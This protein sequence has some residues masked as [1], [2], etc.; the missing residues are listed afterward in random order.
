LRRRGPRV[1]SEMSDGVRPPDRPKH[2]ASAPSPPH[3]GAWFVAWAVVGAGFS[4]SIS[5]IGVFVVPVALVATVALLRRPAATSSIAGIA[6][7]AALLPLF[8]AYRNRSGPGTHCTS[9]P[10]SVS[11]RDLYNPLPWLAIGVVLLAGGLVAQRLT[12]RR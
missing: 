2:R 1:T 8:V 6:S 7:G 12:S 10:T 5:V 11:C 3:R 4:T 9:S